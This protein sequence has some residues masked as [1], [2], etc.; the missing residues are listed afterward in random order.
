MTKKISQA[1]ARA[2]K[3]RVAEFESLERTRRNAWATEWPKGISI[4]ALGVAASTAAAVR[5]ARKLKHAVV[6]T[7]DDNNTLRLFA[8]PLAGDP[9]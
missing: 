7:I 3:K 1:E 8:M 5:T 4:D 6:A 9:A 2:L